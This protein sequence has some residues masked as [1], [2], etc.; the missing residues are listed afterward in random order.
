MTLDS[1][2]PRSRR[3]L[4]AAA[5]GAVAATVATALGRPEPATA[6]AG[7]ALIIGALDNNAGSSDT[8]LRASSSVVAFKVVQNGSGA[9]LMGFAPAASGST[10][11]VYG[12]TDSPDGTGVEARN[13][14]AAGNGVALRA[15]G[16]NNTGLLAT[17]GN[18]TRAAIRGVHGSGGVAVD[19]SA[20]SYGTGVAGSAGP[21]GY[22]V[23]GFVD[24]AGVAVYGSSPSTGFGVWGSSTDGSGIVGTSGTGYAGHFSGKVLMNRTLD[25]IEMGVAP[26]NAV[27]NQAR[28]FVRDN[29]G[30]T[31]L[32]V[33]FATGELQVLAAQA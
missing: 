14:A 27:A 21:G 11:G 1:A 5:V 32:C 31:E 7:S 28:I 6:A 29:G 3:A 20:G 30:K 13:N 19:G 26:G 25:L 18:N 12:R 22:G 8:Q 2:S 15:A 24:G 16:G 10:R 4:L 23:T 17:T 9:A 33:I